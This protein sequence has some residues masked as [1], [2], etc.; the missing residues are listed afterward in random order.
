[1]GQQGEAR[2]ADAVQVDLRLGD[3]AREREPG[4]IGPFPRDQAGERLDPV[5]EARIGAEGTASPCLSA[6]RAARRLPEGDFGP[7]LRSAFL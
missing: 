4:R 3:P 2:R 5:E 1:M 7:V 6:L